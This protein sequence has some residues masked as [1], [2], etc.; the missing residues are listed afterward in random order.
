MLIRVVELE[1][2][3]NLPHWRS[4]FHPYEQKL[5]L[6]LSHSARY[7]FW[8]LKVLSWFNVSISRIFIPNCQVILN[9]FWGYPSGILYV[10]KHILTRYCLMKVDTKCPLIPC[11]SQT[12]NNFTLWGKLLSTM[13]TSWFILSCL[14][15]VPA[16]DFVMEWILNV[17]R[18]GFSL[19]LLV[20][21]KVAEKE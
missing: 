9:I 16:F 11:P 13:A 1:W 8:T 19:F 5:R 20:G 18:I 15:L 21:Y 17:D 7:S 3:W 2:L 10:K 14:P 4:I 6:Q 12:Q